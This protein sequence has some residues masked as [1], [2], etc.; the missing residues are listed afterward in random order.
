VKSLAGGFEE[1][2]PLPPGEMAIRFEERSRWST[3]LFVTR[4]F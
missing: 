3:L 2:A 1:G 4:T